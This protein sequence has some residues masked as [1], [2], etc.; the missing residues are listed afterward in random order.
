M[1]GAILKGWVRAGLDPERIAVVDPGDPVLPAGVTHHRALP[2]DA[3]APDFLLLGIKP[4]M[5]KDVAP[6]LQPLAGPQTTLLSI[7]AGPEV[8]DLRAAFPGV[9]KAVRVMP[10]MAVGIGK[11][12]FSIIGEPLEDATRGRIEALFAPVGSVEWLENE[13]QMHLAIAVAG[14]GPAFVFRFIDA[15]A[16]AAREL[17]MDAGQAARMALATVEGAALLAAESDDDPGV[18][19]DKV[20][21]PGGTTRAGLNVLDADGRINALL[22]DTLEAAARRSAD[23]AEEAKG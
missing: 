23:M 10:N 14:S 2:A 16:A 12:V 17:G 7:L 22:R 15:M 20:A 8:S 3:T 19:A 11:S 4:H 9:G 21:S 18:L 13:A 6:G 1:G 5:L